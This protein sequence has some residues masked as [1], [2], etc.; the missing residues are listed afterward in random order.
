MSRVLPPPPGLARTR[1]LFKSLDT[2]G[3]GY[4]SYAELL[5][6]LTGAEVDWENLDCDRRVVLDRLW[7]EADKDGNGRA[8]F[9]EFWQ[10]VAASRTPTEEELDRAYA[11]FA[12][13][14]KS[15]DGEAGHRGFARFVV[16]SFCFPRHLVEPK[17]AERSPS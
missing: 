10:L 14:D 9:G 8:T 17:R 12:Q 13:L 16:S 7:V 2:S 5:E 15:G 6:G 11:F 1:D 3:D 4:L